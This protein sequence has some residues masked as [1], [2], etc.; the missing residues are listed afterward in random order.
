MIKFICKDFWTEIFRKQID[1]LRTNHKGV[2]VL[3][4]NKFR[5]F[6]H[7]SPTISKVRLRTHSHTD[8]RTAHTRRR[9][10]GG[11]QQLHRVQ[12]RPHSWRPGQPRHRLYRY[13]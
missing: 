3:A 5:L 13:V 1:N 9:C 8:T 2:Y 4:D 6:A 11:G 10:V 7:M 12:L